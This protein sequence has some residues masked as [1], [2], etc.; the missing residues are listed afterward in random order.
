MEF[1]W[2]FADVSIQSIM[3][4]W[5][6]K[7]NSCPD[8][9]FSVAL[10]FTCHPLKW[11]LIT[12]RQKSALDNPGFSVCCCLA[13]CSL[14]SLQ[15]WKGS[16]WHL[17]FGSLSLILHYALK[18]DLK[19]LMRKA[20]EVTFVDAHRPNK[21]EGWVPFLLDSFPKWSLLVEFCPN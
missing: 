13:A 3:Q 4:L 20:G 6:S 9:A 16:H 5:D 10:L 8:K 17:L 7:G 18:Q 11:E 21:N 12:Q 2:F 15:V 19:D 14:L 1:T